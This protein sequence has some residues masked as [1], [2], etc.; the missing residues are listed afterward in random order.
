MRTGIIDPGI[1]VRVLVPEVWGN[2]VY[3]FFVQVRESGPG[4]CTGKFQ[5][6]FGN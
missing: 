3:N 6:K 4:V 5:G 1:L 2:F